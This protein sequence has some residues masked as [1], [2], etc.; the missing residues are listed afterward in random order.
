M[1][2]LGMRLDIDNMTYIVIDNMA[3]VNHLPKLD[4]ALQDLKTPAPSFFP[5]GEETALT[6]FSS[7]C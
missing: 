6:K 5:R 4:M 1:K 3:A 7:K 2:K